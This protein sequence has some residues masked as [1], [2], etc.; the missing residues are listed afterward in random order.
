MAQAPEPRPGPHLA[1]APGSRYDAVELAA[2]AHV[3]LRSASVPV[4]V[5]DADEGG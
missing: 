2:T 1:I 3:V 5:R 4:W